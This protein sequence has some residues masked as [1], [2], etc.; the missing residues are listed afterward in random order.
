MKRIF[1]IFIS[2]FFLNLLWENLH[3]VLYVSYR[4]QTITEI[5]LLRAA[6]FDAVFITVLL[7][8]FA[9]FSVLKTRPW[10]VMVIGV[11]FA[12]CL[13]LFALNT[14]RWIY[15][16]SM[17]I[18]PFLNVGL[19]PTVQLGAISYLLIKTFYRTN[20]HGLSS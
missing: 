9:S 3:S 13:E 1:L 12:I 20:R 19:T 2:A 15:N 10:L 11:I 16:T 4:G 18:L 5:N 14:G 6:L 8:F 7:K 17:P